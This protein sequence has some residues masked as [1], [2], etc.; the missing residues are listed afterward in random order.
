MT[1]VAI[2]GITRSRC[3]H[4]IQNRE[5]LGQVLRQHP[6]HHERFYSE[7]STTLPLTSH[8]AEMG[9][10]PPAAIRDT[11][12]E[13][14][15]TAFGFARKENGSPARP[16]AAGT[17]NEDLSSTELTLTSKPMYLSPPSMQRVRDALPRVAVAHSFNTSA[18]FVKEQD[19]ATRKTIGSHGMKT[20]SLKLRKS[21]SIS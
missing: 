12:Q 4:H 7:F 13:G 18:V 3:Q 1:A 5:G 16:T 2:A 21:Y 17:L 19:R 8:L 14:G 10:V 6:F 9:H 20:L 11:G 15:Y